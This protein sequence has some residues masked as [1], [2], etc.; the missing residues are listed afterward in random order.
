MIRTIQHRARNAFALVLTVPVL[1]GAL[2]FWAAQQYR[3]SIAWISHTRD[4]LARIDRLQLS[5]TAAESSQRGFLLTGES[6]YRSAFLSA[7]DGVETGLADLRHSISDNPQ[8]R[9]NFDELVPAVRLRADK[10]REVLA[11]RHEG[12]LPVPQA[13]SK[14]DEGTDLMRRIRQICDEMI[15]EEGRLLS[16]RTIAQRKTDTRLVIC[17][18]GAILV[19]VILL[20][21]AYQVI[22][23]YGLQRDFAEREIRQLNADLE[24]RVEERTIELQTA[25]EQLRRSNDDLTRFAYVASHDLQEPLRTVGSYAGL[26]AK[27]YKD[28]LDDQANTYIRYVVDGAKRMQTLVQDLLAYSRAGTQALVM[29]ATDVQSVLKEC[30]ENLKIAIAERNAQITSDP[31][32]V[33]SADSKKLVLVFQNLIGNALK[34]SKPGQ[35]PE[36]HV[37]AHREG[38]EWVFSVHDNGIGFEPEYASKIF[39]IF[40]RLHQVG[41]FPG[42]G[43]GLAI[44]KRIVETHG[45][46]IWATSELGA[47]ATFLFT[48]PIDPRRTLLRNEVSPMAEVGVSKGKVTIGQSSENSVDRG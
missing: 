8:Q 32:P 2:T 10:L 37:G 39:E 15:D 38:T 24:R 27:R 47:G 29:Q 9:R 46:H 14:I 25:N 43:I 40:Q 26:L 1:L 21:W 44:C 18:T 34:F 36:I 23:H 11:L 12:N 3:T 45:G 16:V 13:V 35:R 28:Q 17:F 42:T 19:N 41:T 22:K 48:L 5:L 30:E 20:Y 31:L 7:L 4:V 6:R 33:V